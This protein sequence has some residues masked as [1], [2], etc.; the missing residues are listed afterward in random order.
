M[1]DQ[2]IPTDQIPEPFECQT[3][4][5][6][7]IFV[8]YARLD[9]SFVYSTLQ[10][11]NDAEVN[12]WYD[13]GIPPSTE[14]V[15]EIAQAIKKSSLF[16]LFM[17]PQAVSSRFVRNEI[18]YAVSLDKNILTVYLEETLLPEGLSLCLQPYQSLEVN[19]QDWLQKAC[20]AIQAQINDE[21]S[22]LVEFQT[23]T[24]DIPGIDLGVQLRC[25]VFPTVFT[26]FLST[27]YLGPNISYTAPYRHM[28]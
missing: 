3:G 19:D 26:L 4:H 24:L 18:N 12:I 1:T 5:D 23:D 21:A 25:V 27:F 6:P 10:V 7:Y 28:W 14:W 2:S 9:K 8:S 13:E 17:S 16:V 20:L 15:E 22:N 11:F